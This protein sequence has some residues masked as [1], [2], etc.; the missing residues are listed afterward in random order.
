MREEGARERIGSNVAPEM[1]MALQAALAFG[2]GHPER[3]PDWHEQR[4]QTQVIIRAAIE[5]ATEGR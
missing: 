4:L 3:T 2:E 1:L 5:R